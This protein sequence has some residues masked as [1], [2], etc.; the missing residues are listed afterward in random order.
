MKT[1]WIIAAA[2]CAG[3]A[4]FFALRGE[5]DNAF[6]AAVLGAVAWFL[7]YRTQL[8]EKLGDTD[9]ADERDADLGETDG[10]ET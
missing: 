3:T 8:R 4:V 2:L 10:E 5:Y 1:F 6:M 7:N 9:Q